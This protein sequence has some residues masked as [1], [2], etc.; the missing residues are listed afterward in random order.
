MDGNWNI[1]VKLGDSW[2]SD[3]GTRFADIILLE[4][5][6]G[7]EVGDGNGCGVIKGEGFNASEGNVFGCE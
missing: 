4:E 1:R 3:L 5:E 2:G 6:L 7:G